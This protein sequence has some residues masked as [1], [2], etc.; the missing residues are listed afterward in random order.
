MK[1]IYNIIYDCFWW[2]LNNSWKNECNSLFSCFLRFPFLIMVDPILA[3]GKDVRKAFQLCY[4]HFSWACLENLRTSH[5]DLGHWISHQLCPNDCG[6][7]SMFPSFFSL[8][9]TWDWFFTWVSWWYVIKKKSNVNHTYTPLTLIWNMTSNF[10]LEHNKVTHF[11]RNQ[12]IQRSPVVVPL[13]QLVLQPWQPWHLKARESLTMV[14][15]YKC[16]D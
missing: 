4:H 3:P 8:I 9:M 15:T 2:L 10:E 13:A 12:S 7:P 5:V 6:F 16:P 11:S 14:R 1:N